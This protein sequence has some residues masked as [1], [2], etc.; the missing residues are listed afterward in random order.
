MLHFLNKIQRKVRISEETADFE[1][2]SVV[3]AT[4]STSKLCPDGPNGPQ[5]MD[6]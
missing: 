5:T 3:I 1:Y 2:G 6:Q 4:L